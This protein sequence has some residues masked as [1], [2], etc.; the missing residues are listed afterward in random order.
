GSFQLFD[1]SQLTDLRHRLGAA[2]VVERTAT[3]RLVNAFFDRRPIS[4]IAIYSDPGGRFGRTVDRVRVLDGRMPRADEPDAVALN[5][6]AADLL[7]IAPGAV[8]SAP[9]WTP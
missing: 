9:T 3:R 1:D 2:P 4:D 5:E 8:P 6:L 7:H